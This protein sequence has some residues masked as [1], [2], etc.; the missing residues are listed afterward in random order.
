MNASRFC[1]SSRVPGRGTLS[2]LARYIQ[3][4]GDRMRQLAGVESVGAVSAMPFI[5]SNIGMK[6]S[7]S[8]E[9]QAAAR[10]DESDA[11]ITIAT[12]GYFP[13]L[14][15][16]L[17]E[18][19][20]F[21]EHDRETTAPVA[22]IT[23][24]LARRQ[25]PNGT[26]IGKKVMYQLEG[27]QRQAKIVGIVGA[28][29]HD[30]LD[31]P[32]RAELIIPHAQVPYGGMTFVVR[33]TSD[34]VASIRALKAQIHTVDRTQAINRATTLAELIGRS[35]IDRRFTLALFLTFAALATM[36]AAAGVYGVISVLTAQRT[37]EFGV[38]LA[39]GAGRLEIV[40]MVVRQVSMIAAA[41]L[42]LGL[43]AAL[44]IGRVMNRFLYEIT[45][46]DPTTFVAVL[47]V[48]TAL[49]FLACLERALRATRVD[50]LIALRTE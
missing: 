28:V 1:K 14:R 37:R 43:A 39:L 3:Q 41:G 38:R 6:S 19:R 30:G 46:A 24:T 20:P 21:D 32:A 17:L 5:E 36:L 23:A 26:A 31:R 35:L 2:K 10:Q 42:A 22:V 25:W 47:L 13:T 29:K 49:S 8:I 33:T 11:F 15:I 16:P 9:G 4:I 50:P 34:P 27:N 45:P 44:V 12:P 48:L 7:L 40:A 18:G